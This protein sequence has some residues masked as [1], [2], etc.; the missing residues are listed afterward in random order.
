VVYHHRLN[1]NM[2][3]IILVLFSLH[4]HE[5]VCYLFRSKSCHCMQLDSATINYVLKFYIFFVF[6]LFIVREN[7]AD[8]I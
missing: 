7:L 2:L 6:W 5:T 3:L 4:M 1:V 8:L